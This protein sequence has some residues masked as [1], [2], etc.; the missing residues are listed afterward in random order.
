M[1]AGVQTVR[2]GHGKRAQERAQSR[3]SPRPHTHLDIATRERT[4]EHS[5]DLAACPA[6]SGATL[7]TRA[8]TQKAA[9][10][11]TRSRRRIGSAPNAL[12]GRAISAMLARI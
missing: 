5:D 7:E 11:Q 4:P 2:A 1:Q 9:A 12:R 3:A 8:G 6:R 10:L